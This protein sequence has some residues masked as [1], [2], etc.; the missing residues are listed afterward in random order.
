MTPKQYL[1]QPAPFTDLSTFQLATL[2]VLAREGPQYGLALRDELEASTDM[3]IYGGKLYPN[4]NQLADENLIEKRELD[5]RTNEYALTDEGKRILQRYHAWL[6]EQ[7]TPILSA[8][9]TDQRMGEIVVDV[10]HAI[11]P[12]KYCTRFTTQ[13]GLTNPPENTFCFGYVCPHC[14]DTVPLKG[15]PHEFRDTPIRCP[16]CTWVAVLDGPALDQFAEGVKTYE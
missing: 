4:L 16:S 12:E 11:D 9:T 14:R 8:P 15:E 1:T 13:H 6:S 2:A 7:L 10:P 5:K 3:E